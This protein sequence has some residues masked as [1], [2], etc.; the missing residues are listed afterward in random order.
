V[1]EFEMKSR[2]TVKRFTPIDLVLTA[3]LHPA[4]KNTL[5]IGKHHL[6]DGIRNNQI[7]VIPEK[8]LLFL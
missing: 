8:I 2:F 1:S 7:A 6:A 5:E 4:M 3:L